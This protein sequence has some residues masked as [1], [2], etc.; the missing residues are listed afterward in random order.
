MSTQYERRSR[1][2]FI[3]HRRGQQC[4]WAT[5]AGRR[6]ELND[7]S[8][9]GFSVPAENC[10]VNGSAFE[11]VLTRSA[12]PDQIRGSAQV[13]NHVMAL[14]GGLLGCRFVSFE[15]EGEERLHDW[16]VAHVIAGATVRITEKDARAIV[17]G[18][19]LI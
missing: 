4:F 15:G 9:A 18:R 3:A 16:L 6:I 11:F 2:R 19:S 13:V 1:Q 7:L 8:M 5:I 12:V 14:D 17:N 10:P